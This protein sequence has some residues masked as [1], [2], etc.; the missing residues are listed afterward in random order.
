MKGQG[1]DGAANMSGAYK[2]VQARIRER[3]PDAV[4]S[5]CKAHCLNL[6]IVHSCKVEFVRNMMDVVQI[7]AFAFSY[8]AKRLAQYKQ[9]LEGDPESL[10]QMQERRHLQNL[11]ETR[12]AARADALT[13]F[14]ASIRT[15]VTALQTLSDNGDSKA[16][17]HCL[18]I[19]QFG[20]IITLVASQHVLEAL[21]PLS[22]TLQKKDCNLVRALTDTKV[23]IKTLQVY[24]CKYDCNMLLISSFVKLRL[25][26]YV[27]KRFTIRMITDQ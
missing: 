24:K 2:G 15:V 17:G 25:I 5:H 12:W 20:F 8:S 27:F 6:T 18:S 9:T 22:L 13:T 1:Y 7:I 11:C 4:Y 26:N 10:E 19:Q 21:V 3:I 16:T 23:V 14:L